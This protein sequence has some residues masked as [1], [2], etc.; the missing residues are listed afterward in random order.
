MVANLALGHLGLRRTA[1]PRPLCGGGDGCHRLVE[2]M[3]APARW[4]AATLARP[5]ACLVRDGRL[6]GGPPGTPT[7]CHTLD[8]L[9][10]ARGLLGVGGGGGG[11][12]LRGYL[13]G[14]H[15]EATAGFPR[16][17]PL[18]VCHVHPTP[19]PGPMPAPWRVLAR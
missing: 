9:G 14:G 4:P 19:D 11:G 12:C 1:S 7:R 10:D 16:E 18:S 15:H 6:S 5:A 3:L 13:P 17:S 8:V 2:R